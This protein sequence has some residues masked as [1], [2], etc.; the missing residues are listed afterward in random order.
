MKI[1][2]EEMEVCMSQQ[3][4]FKRQAKGFTLIELLVVVAIIAVL[5]SILLPSL[6]QA[7]MQA[8][9]VVCTSNFRQIGV[10]M[11][12]YEMEYNSFP[13][14]S[15]NPYF[16]KDNY[17][18]GQLARYLGFSGNIE[19]GL[20]YS[21]GNW[22]G[23]QARY[24]DRQVPIFQCPGSYNIPSPYGWSGNSYGINRY[25]WTTCVPTQYMPFRKLEKPDKTFV[26]MDSR[27][28]II[29]DGPEAACG[30][31]HNNLKNILFAD[32]HITMNYRD[33][34]GYIWYDQPNWLAEDLWGDTYFMWVR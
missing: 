30:R 23:D 4:K 20:T 32:L 25:L 11:A 34:L 24:P 6:S 8:K 27:R 3:Y 12:S 17:W 26:L 28:Y 14:I 2:L 15:Y 29:P 18:Q 33:S 16:N 21:P 22:T 1:Q 7:R 9:R 31:P 5:I 10:A 19:S 13:T